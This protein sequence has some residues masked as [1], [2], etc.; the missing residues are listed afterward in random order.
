MGKST[1]TVSR[2]QIPYTTE[3]ETLS[4][5]ECEIP[6]AIPSSR[7]RK[8]RETGEYFWCPNGHRI[9]YSEG[10]NDKLRRQLADSQAIRSSLSA[11]LTAETD[12]RKAAERKSSARKGV[13]TRMRGKLAQGKCTECDTD[14]PDLAGHMHEAHPDFEKADS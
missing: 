11:A 6:F 9:C 4:C 2:Q 7:H 3:L 13:I 12:Q 8:L 10:Q 5:G 1:I 14:F